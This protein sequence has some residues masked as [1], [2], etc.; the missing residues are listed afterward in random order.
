MTSLKSLSGKRAGGLAAALATPGTTTVAAVPDGLVGKVV[1]DLA[2]DAAR[3][4]VFVARD[5]QRLDEVRRTIGFFAPSVELLDFPAWD[6]L[7][8]D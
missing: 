7:P 5:G 4:I 8:Y 2:R 1:A 3:R 6:C